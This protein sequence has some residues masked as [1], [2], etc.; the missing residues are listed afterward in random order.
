MSFLFK[1]KAED[2]QKL[3]V[4][5][6]LPTFTASEKLED[7]LYPLQF[8]GNY[9]QECTN[10]LLEEEL[11]TTEEIYEIEKSF[12]VVRQN[13]VLVRDSIRAFE[14]NIHEMD[15]VSTNFT[16]SMHNIL[17]II[18]DA[19]SG[20]DGLNDNTQS[21]NTSFK[22]IE[23]TFMQFLASYETIDKY[24]SSIIDIADQ[25]NLLALNA[26]IEAARAGESGKG[27]AVVAEEVKK[28]SDSIKKLVENVNVSMGDL[29]SDTAK[30]SSSLNDS[31]AYLSKNDNY[32]NSTTSIFDN[33]KNVVEVTNSETLKLDQ[34]LVDSKEKMNLITKNLSDSEH[35]YDEVSDNIEKINVMLPEK[36]IIFEDINH[37][38]MQVSP[39]IGDLLKK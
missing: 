30:L 13:Q 2:K 20:I 12:D 33:I 19:K 9:L 18:R 23:D 31:K 17:E 21:I 8:M 26:S 5:N 14:G 37:M 24:T 34:V 36:G 7:S 6:E 1:K 10:R 25:T 35:Y 22:M 27:F 38:L 32:V 15:Q 39:L 4:A 3:G 29:K 28:L 11:N 16:K